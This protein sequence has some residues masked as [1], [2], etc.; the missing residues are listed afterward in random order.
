MDHEV[1]SGS[2]KKIPIY[3]HKNY[4]APP[5]PSNAIVVDEMLRLADVKSG[6]DVVYDPACGDGR[7]PIRAVQEPFCAARAVGIDIDKELCKIA[8]EKVKTSDLQDKVRIKNRDI[9][10]CDLSE[11]DVVTLYLS[12]PSN[13][14]IRPKLERELKKTARVVSHSFRME[15]WNPS[16]TSDIN[17]SLGNDKKYAYPR[18]IYLYRMDEI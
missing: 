15:S 11:A 13:E 10:K 16:K 3:A 12:E 18:R 4:L 1:F 8:R 7:I 14:R 6:K 2:L 5:F 17:A 9:F